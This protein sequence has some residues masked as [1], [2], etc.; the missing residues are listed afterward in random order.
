MEIRA[1]SMDDLEFFKFGLREVRTI[2]RRPERD[3]PVT[4]DDVKSLIYGITRGEIRVVDDEDGHPA[5]FLYYR[6]DHTIMYVSGSI[7]WIDLLFVREDVR[8]KGIGKSLYEDAIMIAMDMG[9]DRIVIDIFESN[10]R[11]KAFHDGIGFEPIYTI[12]GMDIRS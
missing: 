10:E 7:F 12:Y 3:I 5:A 6:T 1:A 4:D 9:L 11:S 8:G 2:E